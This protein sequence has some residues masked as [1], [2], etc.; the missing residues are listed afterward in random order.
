MF[1]A[2]L[3]LAPLVAAQAQVPLPFAGERR[4]WKE[5]ITLERALERLQ[6]ASFNPTTPPV[7]DYRTFDVDLTWDFRTGAVQGTGTLVVRTASPQGQV[8][9][10]M[11]SGLTLSATGPGGPLTVTRQSFGNGLD[12]LVIHV[13]VGSADLSLQLSWSGT[14]QC[15]AGFGYPRCTKGAAP[16]AWLDIGSGIPLPMDSVA[17]FSVDRAQLSWTLRTPAGFT[18]QVAGDFISESE[19]A[20]TRTSRWAMQQPCSLAL[21]SW[22]LTGTGLMRTASLLMDSP[23]V[24]ASSAQAPAL[25]TWLQSILPREV[26]R[27]GPRLSKGV[28]QTIIPRATDFIGTA[29]YGM[30]LVNELYDG[31]GPI[32]HEEIWAHENIHQHFAVRGYPTDITVSSFMTEG[33]TTLL[34]LD[35]TTRA[36]TGLERD[37]ALAGRLREPYLQIDYKFPAVQTVP[38]ALSRAGDAPQEAYAHSAWAYFKGAATHELLRLWVGEAVFMDGLKRYL[39]ACDARPCDNDAYRDAM[40]AASGKPMGPFFDRF[41]FG[42][43]RPVATIDFTPGDTLSVVVDQGAAGPLPL[44]LWIE[45]F[46]GELRREPVLVEQAKQTFTFTPGF[47]ARSVRANPRAEGLVKLDSAVSGDVDFDGEVDGFDVIACA[48]LVGH[49]LSSPTVKPTV[50][51]TNIEFDRRCDPNH[52]GK[53]TADDVAALPFGSLRTAQ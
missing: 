21:A 2:L 35:Y 16:F 25:T 27:F 38:L 31:L 12:Y 24:H 11:D 1:T 39:A 22:I 8:P 14:L 44:E 28:A 53:I 46:A 7:L 15:G 52:D 43:T 36:L 50:W 45:G 37:L 40:A 29:S 10:M 49:T 9:L 26:D 41:V 42:G 30:S 48:R 23:V 47:T 13:A 19:D 6:P 20:T 18:V 3:A 32:A 34:Q 51:R 33:I 4:A 17:G 5:R